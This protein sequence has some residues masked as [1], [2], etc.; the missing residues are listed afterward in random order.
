MLDREANSLYSGHC[1]RF[2]PNF[3]AA[4]RKVAELQLDAKLGKVDCT[5]HQRFCAEKGITSYPTMK[6]YKQGEELYHEYTGPRR[7]SA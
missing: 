7:V 1:R 5:I 2:A 3:D 6:I 4:A